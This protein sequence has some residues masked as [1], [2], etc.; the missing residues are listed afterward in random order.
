[1]KKIICLLLTAV[2]LSFSFSSCKEKKKE[3]AAEQSAVPTETEI[4]QL[5][6]QIT[7]SIL[8]EQ[9]EFLNN[10]FDTLA[11]RQALS[12]Y[13]IVSS[14]LDTELGSQALAYNLKFGDFAVQAV[15]NGGDFRFLKYYIEDEKAHLI[16]R[17]YDDFGLQIIDYI[18]HYDKNHN[19]KIEDGYI[20]NMSSS[21]VTSIMYDIRYTIMQN[22]DMQDEETQH[23]S[24][25]LD[26]FSHAKYTDLLTH[27]QTYQNELQLYPV[28][29]YLYINALNETSKDFIADLNNLK[30]LDSRCILVHELIYHT[31]VGNYEAAEQSM[32]KLI[33]FTGEDP[34]YW[35]FY[36]KALYNAK[37]YELALDA[38][39]NAE[40]GMDEIWDLWRGKQDCNYMLQNKEAFKQGYE[41]AKE[42]FGMTDE[43]IA[44]DCHHFYSKM[45]L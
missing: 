11:I 3:V 37:E 17:T 18:F 7:N 13:S 5:A 31:N 21:L 12:Q 29:N 42:S 25:A 1:M 44:E 4:Q 9:P 45:S 14:Q 20:Y 34:I 22:L 38:Y 43:E 26:L 27:L 15:K 2:I 28:Y 33:D 41:V 32:Q 36:G 40:K 10:L 39:T 6:T 30:H 24:Q 23:L 35:L 19:L 16:F 8:N